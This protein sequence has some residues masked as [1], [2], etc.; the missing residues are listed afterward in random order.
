MWQTST[1]LLIDSERHISVANTVGSARLATPRARGLFLHTGCSSR[2]VPPSSTQLDRS[3]CSYIRPGNTSSLGS[4]RSLADILTSWP[5]GRALSDRVLP[6]IPGI[7]PSR[8]CY[9][10]RSQDSSSAVIYIRSQKYI[11]IFRDAM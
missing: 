3:G 6:S 7:H 1:H 9:T 4:I 11:N 5:Q 10:S 8:V 2:R